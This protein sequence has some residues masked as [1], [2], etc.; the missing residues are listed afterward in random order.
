MR[1]KTIFAFFVILAMCFVFAGLGHAG[2]TKSETSWKLT[3]DG[4]L[5]V[6][7]TNLELRGQDPASNSTNNTIQKGDIVVVNGTSP[8][9]VNLAQNNTYSK[10][11]FGIAENATHPNQ[12]GWFVIAG[13]ADVALC[14]GC[15]AT[16]GRGVFVYTGNHTSG[17]DSSIAHLG[18]AN[19]TQTFNSTAFGLVLEAH[20]TTNGTDESD[21]S[22]VKT[23]LYNQQ[24]M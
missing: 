24:A 16:V 14:P 23:L 13:V 18:R 9:G 2:S 20:T 22:T 10:Y 1:L 11:I 6:W 8:Y 3:D 5:A 12:G 7:M 21:N 19:C 15:E 4:G 17:E